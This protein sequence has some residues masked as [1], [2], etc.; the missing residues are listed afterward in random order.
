MTTNTQPQ[1]GGK[2][3]EQ[4]IAV[5]KNLILVIKDGNTTRIW[6][7]MEVKDENHP[8]PRVGKTAKDKA[9]GAA[10]RNASNKVT[11]ASWMNDSKRSAANFPYNTCNGKRNRTVITGKGNE[12][13]RLTYK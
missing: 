11:R 10:A 13:I 8:R 5:D 12:Q 7:G 2:A 6:K 4:R 1:K 9:S 3:K